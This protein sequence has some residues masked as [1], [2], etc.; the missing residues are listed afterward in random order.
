MDPLFNHSTWKWSQ[1]YALE[2]RHVFL[3][4]YLNFFSPKFSVKTSNFHWGVMHMHLTKNT[5]KVSDQITKKSV[6]T[7]PVTL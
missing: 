7:Q 2:M 6:I 1:N 4:L 3:N 5:S